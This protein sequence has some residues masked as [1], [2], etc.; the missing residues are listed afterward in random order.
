MAEQTSLPDLS[1]APPVNRPHYH[2]W[3]MAATGRAFFRLARGFHTR[4]AARQ[5]AVRRQPD[6]KR[7][8]VLECTNPAC[9]PKL[10]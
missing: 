6:P 4:Q 2:V 1:P 8:M 3:Y 10:D 5:F 9:A 7:R